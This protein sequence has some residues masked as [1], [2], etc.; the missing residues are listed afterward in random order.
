VGAAEPF[1]GVADEPGRTVAWAPGEPLDCGLERGAEPAVLKRISSS[2]PRIPT[3]TMA[4]A[5]ISAGDSAVWRGF[6]TPRS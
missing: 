2:R 4:M 5:A 6:V 1:A 3:A